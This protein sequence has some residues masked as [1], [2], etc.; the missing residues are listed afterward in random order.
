[1]QAMRHVGKH[2][3]RPINR[4]SAA[5][6]EPWTHRRAEG[7]TDAQLNVPTDTTDWTT[8]GWIALLFLGRPVGVHLLKRLGVCPRLHTQSTQAARDLHGAPALQHTPPW[9]EHCT[10]DPCLPASEGG[11]AAGIQKSYRIAYRSNPRH[12]STAH[13]KDSSSR[14]QGGVGQPWT[15]KDGQRE[16]CIRAH[17]YSRGS[18]LLETCVGALQG[19][20]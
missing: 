19:L 6:I 17:C 1:M 3:G 20:V 7:P 5:Q 4:H 14:G 16:P 15:T 9:A 2:T 12:H 13:Y 10:A 8:G 18:G 11:R